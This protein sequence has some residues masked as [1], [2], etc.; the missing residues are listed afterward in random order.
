[1]CQHFVP[2]AVDK[3]QRI[4]APGARDQNP[5]ERKLIEKFTGGRT[6]HLA[7][8]LLTP[9]GKPLTDREI[10]RMQSADEVLATLR[11]AVTRFGPVT[12]RDVKPAWQPPDKGAGLRPDGSARLALTV[13]YTDNGSHAQPV[14]D[15]I[16]LAKERWQA[17]LPRDLRDGA[18]YAIAEATVREL[19]RAVSASSDLSNLIRPTD[20]TT[21]K[22]T[23]TVRAGSGGTWEVHLSGELVGTRKYVNG[24]EL[25]PGHTRLDGVLFLDKAGQPVRLLLVGKGTFRMPWDRGPRPTA[26]VAEWRA[27]GTERETK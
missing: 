11:D 12:P 8:H 26:A 16:L 15:S 3:Q 7:V 19:S 4:H 5:E 1:V 20:L 10:F 24:P 18:T 27:R 23:G 14:F 6:G 13:R 2:I 17:L 21:A 25:L 22:L 9:D